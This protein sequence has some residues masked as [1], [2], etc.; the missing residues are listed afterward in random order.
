[1]YN[2]EM[3]EIVIARFSV[4]NIITTSMG[5]NTDFTIG[6]ENTVLRAGRVKVS[7]DMA[8]KWSAAAAPSSY[9]MNE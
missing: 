7:G 6:K 4:E 3:P 1:M 8:D 9:A 2:F 5:D